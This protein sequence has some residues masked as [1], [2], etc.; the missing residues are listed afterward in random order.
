M[1]QMSSAL[2]SEVSTFYSVRTL[3]SSLRYGDSQLGG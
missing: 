3:D 1:L 2:G